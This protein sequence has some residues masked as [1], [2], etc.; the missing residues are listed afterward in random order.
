MYYKIIQT[1]Y[2]GCCYVLTFVF[3][4][5][6]FIAYTRTGTTV[7]DDQVDVLESTTRRRVPR[8]GIDAMA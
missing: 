5:D 8:D 6:M 1:C 2:E 4:L 7:A 3:N